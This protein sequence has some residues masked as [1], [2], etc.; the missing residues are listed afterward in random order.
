MDPRRVPSRLRQACSSRRYLGCTALC[1]GVVCVDVCVSGLGL[2]FIHA[3]LARRG[4]AAAQATLNCCPTLPFLFGKK[5]K[6]LGSSWAP[7][8]Q[9]LHAAQRSIAQI[10]AVRVHSPCIGTVDPFRRHAP[11]PT[12]S[13]ACFSNE[14]RHHAKVNSLRCKSLCCCAAVLEPRW[15]Q[16]SDNR[17]FG[18]VCCFESKLFEAPNFASFSFFFFFFDQFFH[19]SQS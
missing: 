6:K 14:D 1:C 19:A 9:Q 10:M 11:A 15:T 18:S 8:K 5:S 7:F 2:K 12:P 16:H 17:D 3:G 4:C 13:C